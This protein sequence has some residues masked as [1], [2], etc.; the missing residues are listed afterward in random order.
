MEHNWRLIHNVTYLR[1]HDSW[2]RSSKYTMDKRYHLQLMVLIKMRKLRCDVSLSGFL[3]FFFCFVLWLGFSLWQPLYPGALFVGLSGLE[4]TGI[5]LSAPFEWIL[6]LK[7]CVTLA[8]LSSDFLWMFVWH[9]W[10]YNEE[11]EKEECG[12]VL[13]R[14]VKGL[15]RW[16]WDLEHW[17]FL[18]GF[19]VHLQQ[20]SS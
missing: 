6:G 10:S 15:E 11:W 17:M 14:Q 16:L 3:Y 5:H 12:E 18:Y 13:K 20:G 8:L 9:S 2:Q 7:T 4:L 1:T 19:W